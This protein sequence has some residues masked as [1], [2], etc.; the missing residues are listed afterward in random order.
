MYAV[1]EFIYFIVRNI[2]ELIIWLV[3]AYAVLSWLISFQIVNLRNRIVYSISRFLEA[4]V[5]PML[6][7]FRRFL[8]AP[9]GLD[10]SPILLI[11][12]I[13]GV[14]RFLL[15]AFFG[16]LESLTGGAVAV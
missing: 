7:P 1:L 11:L 15:P 8:P 16:W 14:I 5:R 13:E 2:L 3:V 4:V 10:F 9:G 12:I 6:A